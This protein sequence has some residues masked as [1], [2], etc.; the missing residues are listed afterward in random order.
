MQIFGGGRGSRLLYL[1]HFP[2]VSIT[3]ALGHRPLVVVSIRRLHAV[4]S[5]AKKALAMCS[6][7]ERTFHLLVPAVLALIYL[8]HAQPPKGRGVGNNTRCPRTLRGESLDFSLADLTSLSVLPIRFFIFVWGVGV[9][10]PS[11]GHVMSTCDHIHLRQI[12]AN[13]GKDTQQ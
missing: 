1:Q 6:F 8:F 12:S 9:T 5:R 13:R 11:L 4:T 3:E 2:R 7:R 10:R